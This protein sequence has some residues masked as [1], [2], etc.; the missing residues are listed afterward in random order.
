MRSRLLAVVWL[1]LLAVAPAWAGAPTDQLRQSID[2]VIEILK[3]PAL[4]SRVTE[5]RTALRRAIEPTFDFAET[6][7]LALGRYW[8][9]RTEQERKQFITVF[10]DLLELTYFSRIEGYSG[11]KVAYLGDSAEGDYATVR[12]RI[13]T[14][15][16]Q[17]IPIDYR[18]RRV[19][20][21]W[22]VYDIIIENIGLVQNYRS[23][24]N[25]IIQT[26]SYQE[27][28]KKVEAKREE[29]RNKREEET[30]RTTKRES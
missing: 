27:L 12:T 25:T 30:P 24:F 11:E 19:D 7:R 15:K 26:S 2:R 5:R 22:M 23:Q 14:K 1:L 8:R 13:I 20:G 9:D 6:A 29:L 18:V 16:D 4:K 17:E 10:G 21:R 28:V 3:D